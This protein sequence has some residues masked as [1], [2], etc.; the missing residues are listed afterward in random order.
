[1][2]E[3]RPRTIQKYVTETGQCPYDDWIEGLRD[4]RTQAIIATR[5]NRV[6]QGNF[7]L[8]RKLEGGIQ[9]LKVDFGPG[10][11][12]YFGEDGG[13]IVILLCGGDKS[14]QTKDIETATKYWA[15]YKKE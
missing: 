14:T 15:D 12:V 5:L 9:E 8:C 1:M 13:S 2:I 10:L 3:T 4:K 11:R 6:A 7:G